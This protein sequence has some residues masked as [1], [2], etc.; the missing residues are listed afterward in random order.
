MQMES[1]TSASKWKTPSN[2]K[3]IISRKA[4]SKF[5]LENSVVELRTGRDVPSPVPDFLLRL[6]DDESSENKWSGSVN[7]FRTTESTEIV[8]SVQASS[9][10]GLVQVIM[11]VVLEQFEVRFIKLKQKTIPYLMN[12]SASVSYSVL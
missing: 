8:Y 9:C 2:P 5:L 7:I 11:Q 12:A 10:T 3:L 6:H 1:P 4:E